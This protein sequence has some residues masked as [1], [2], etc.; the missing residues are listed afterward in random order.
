MPTSSTTTWVDNWMADGN[1]DQSNNNALCNY[2]GGDWC[3]QTCVTNCA[4]KSCQF[5]CGQTNPYDWI[6]PNAG[7]QSWTHGTWN[8]G[9]NWL[10]SDTSVNLAIAVCILIPWSMGN[11]STIDYYWG[12]DLTCSISYDSND[13]TKHY[14]GWGFTYDQCTAEACCENIQTAISAGEPMTFEEIRTCFQTNMMSRGQWWEWDDGWTGYSWNVPVWD[15]ACQMG[16]CIDKDVC[17]CYTGWEGSICQ[18]AICKDCQKGNWIAPDVWEW[19]YGYIYSNCS[20]PTHSI[21]CDHGVVSGVDL[22]TWDAGWIGEIW[23]T[24]TWTYSWNNGWWKDLNYWECKPMYESSSPTS[25]WDR[26]KWEYFDTNWY[27][28]DNSGCTAWVDGYY[29]S[30]TD[31]MWRSCSINY[32]SNCV[33]WDSTKWLSWSYPR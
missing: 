6:D 11:G 28:W 27:S 18:Q 13:P 15:P 2:D 29:Y 10:T 23:D 4:T 12:R 8:T 33:V 5:T 21:G 3:R 30:S 25:L 19:F 24:P 1:C 16:T 7:C 22:C 26:I 32:D 31:L 20:T 17:E 14:P 9:S